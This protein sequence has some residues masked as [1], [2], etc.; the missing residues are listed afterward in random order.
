MES[1]RGE[2]VEEEEMFGE[3]ITMKG[4]RVLL[5]DDN[6]INLR[7]LAR[8]FASGPFKTLEWQVE[9]ATS[10]EEAL[11]KI[12]E[13]SGSVGEGKRYDLVVFD[14]NMLPD[15]VLG[16]DASRILRAKDKRVLI[17]GCTGDSTFDDKKLSEASGQDVFWP[18]PAPLSKQALEELTSALVKRRRVWG[19]GHA[20]K[21]G[22]L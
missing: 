2:E 13:T 7:L 5:A 4:W 17:V 19:T 12:S 22:E 9:T 20:G 18:K 8:K 1:R 21:N 15:G 3:V 10:G 11:E 16:T 6:D 14:E